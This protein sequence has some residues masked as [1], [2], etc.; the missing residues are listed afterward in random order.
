MSLIKPDTKIVYDF[1]ALLNSVHNYPKSER[2]GLVYEDDNL[3]LSSDQLRQLQE[4]QDE[5]GY[6]TVHGHDKAD[7]S[8]YIKPLYLWLPAAHAVKKQPK[9]KGKALVGKR[10]GIK[11][12]KMLSAP[13]NVGGVDSYR[14]EGRPALTSD[15]IESLRDALLCGYV[16]VNCYDEDDDS[17]RVVVD[18]TREHELWL[19]AKYV[20]VVS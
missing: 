2:D 15:H 1:N 4:Q 20:K 8:I 12:R 11:F 6:L 16:V 13:E 5:V 7:D 17:V 19:P 14:A 9:V 10:V 18:A 3:A